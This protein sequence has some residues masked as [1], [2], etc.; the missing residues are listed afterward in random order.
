VIQALAFD[1]GGVLVPSPLDEFAKVDQEYG[2][3]AGTIMARFRGGPEFA[4]CETGQ[5]A[6]REF[7]RGCVAAIARDHGVRV[8]AARLEQMMNAIMG[9]RLRPEMLELVTAVKAS[10]YRTALL[11]NIYAERRAWLHALFPPGTIDVFGDSSQLGMRKP[12]QRIYDKLV[13][14]LG[15][16]P[17]EIAFIDD[18]PENLVPARAMG[19][20][21]ILFETPEQVHQDL[22]DIGVRF[23]TVATP[24][25]HP[26]S[27]PVQ[28]G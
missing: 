3:P 5:L 20:S 1:V 9:D 22:I 14:L 18:F 8:P 21:T 11:T 24:H 13:A 6:V 19:M 15:C 27:H 4:R 23:T 2:L 7:F 12:E 26:G 16:S 28:P 25:R 17:D 10:G